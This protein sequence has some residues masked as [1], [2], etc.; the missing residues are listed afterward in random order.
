VAAIRLGVREFGD[1]QPVLLIN[2]I[3]AHVG[4]WAAMERV[5]PGTRVIAFDA[6]GT[7]RHL[8]RASTTG[9]GTARLLRYLHHHARG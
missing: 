2:G 8:L 3:G 7:G 4:M 5:L 9:T 6:P 1:G